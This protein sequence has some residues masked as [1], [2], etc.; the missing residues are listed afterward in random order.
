MNK[1]TNANPLPRCTYCALHR[2][3]QTSVSL[4]PF[5][6]GHVNENKLW[7]YKEYE[8]EMHAINYEKLMDA[9]IKM[10]QLR[11]QHVRRVL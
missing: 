9:T 5:F 1:N 8:L 10:Q 7:K 3:Q 11:M 2:M 6:T 4:Q